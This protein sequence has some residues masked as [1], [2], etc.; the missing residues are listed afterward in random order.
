MATH[1][2]IDVLPDREADTLTAWLLAHPGT[3]VIC[4]DRAG[5]YA[6]AASTG[7]PKAIQVADR[8]HLRHNLAERVEKTVAAH[9][10]CLR[11]ADTTPPTP[12][13]PVVYWCRTPIRDLRYSPV[14]RRRSRA[15]RGRRA[16][17]SERR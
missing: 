15:S 9:H 17:T 13:A 11:H 14:E 16:E 3:K 4:R 6:E 10:G 1:R 2:P 8:W 5:A 7:A 12:P